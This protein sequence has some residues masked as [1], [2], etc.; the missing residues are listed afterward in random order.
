MNQQEEEYRLSQRVQKY[1]K[2]PWK[3][4]TGPKLANPESVGR[5]LQ[6]KYKESKRKREDKEKGL[7]SKRGKLILNKISVYFYM[8]F[9]INLTYFLFYPVFIRVKLRI[10]I[11]ELHIM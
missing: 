4:V 9:W 1:V 11:Q 3:V 10:V 7:E 6:R 8:I 5:P 2:D